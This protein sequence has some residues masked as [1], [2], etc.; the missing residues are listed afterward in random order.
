[1]NTN[2]LLNPARL[3]QLLKIDISTNYIKILGSIAAFFGICVFVAT[4]NGDSSPNPD[5]SDPFHLNFFGFAILFI[6]FMFTSVLFNEL[7]REHERQFYLTLPASNLEKFTTKWIESII[8]FPI[9]FVAL[10]A[11]FFMIIKPIIMAT[12]GCTLPD[13]SPSNTMILFFIKLYISLSGIFLLG[14]VVFGNF[15]AVKTIASI[16]VLGAIFGLI[17]FIFF[18][19]IFYDFFHGWEIHPPHDGREPAPW[20]QDFMSKRMPTILEYLMW[21]AIPLFTW[22]VAYFK[23]KEKEV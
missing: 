17:V 7:N 21:L 5:P 15:S 22:V 9:V 13:F 19:V 6:G 12:M 3:L 23:L 14:A 20:I 11:L 2:T 4:L 16:A 10:Y 18:R 8:L 1:M